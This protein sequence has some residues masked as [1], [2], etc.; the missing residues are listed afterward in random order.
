MRE[1]QYTHAI[2]FFASGSMYQ[3]IKNISDEKKVSLSVIVRA[4]IL[5]Y[6]EADV[7]LEKEN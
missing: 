7:Y 6:L 5:K 2:T 3:T 1:K 4:A